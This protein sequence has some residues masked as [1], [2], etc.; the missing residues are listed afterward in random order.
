VNEEKDVL[1]TGTD[2]MGRFWICSCIHYRLACSPIQKSQVAITVDMTLKIF[3]FF[4]N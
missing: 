3:F 4:K 2:Y 1:E